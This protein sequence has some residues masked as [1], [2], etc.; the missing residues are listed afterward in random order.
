MQSKKNT[1]RGKTWQNLKVEILRGA[2][3]G[4]KG[5]LPRIDVAWSERLDSFVWKRCTFSITQHLQLPWRN[6]KEKYSNT[7]G[8]FLEEPVLFVDNYFFAMPFA[9][10]GNN[11][12]VFLNSDA[13][14]TRNQWHGK[15]SKYFFI[16]L[17]WI[18]SV[19]FSQRKSKVLC[20]SFC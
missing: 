13:R 4:Y 19:I 18:T 17:F 5:T 6:H 15:E 7:F 8:I 1:Y 2:F 14:T 11:V 3:I 9:W 20:L 16:L 10:N 12:R